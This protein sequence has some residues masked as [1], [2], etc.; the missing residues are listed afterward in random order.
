MPIHTR[1]RARSASMSLA[2]DGVFV[3]REGGLARRLA[4]HLP[5]TDVAAA[6]DRWRRVCSRS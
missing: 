1:V 5:T 2:R 6:L 3:E 4:G